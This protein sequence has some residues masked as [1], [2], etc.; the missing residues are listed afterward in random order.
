MQTDTVAVIGLGSI[1]RRHCKNLIDLGYKVIGY[2]IDPAAIAQT[3]NLILTDAPRADFSA[4]HNQIEAIIP[5]HAVIIAN[6]S[7]YHQ[8]TLQNCVDAGK[9]C[10]VEKPLA[11]QIDGIEEILESAHAKGLKVATGFNLRYR[12]VVQK[13]KEILPDLG[14]LFWARFICA[15]YLPDW[16]PTQDY[17]NNYAANPLTGGVIFDVAHEIDLAR[18]FLGN[19]EVITCFAERTG[20]LDML[21]EDKADM[22]IK[23]VNGVTSNIHLDYITRPRQRHFEIAGQHGVLHVNLQTHEMKLTGIE[24]DFITHQTLVPDNPN[25]EYKA[26]LEGFLNAIRSNQDSSPSGFDGLENL[27][28]ILKARQLAGLPGTY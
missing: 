19:G 21:S 9:H 27:K 16:R 18:F 20:L 28:H 24:G 15:S 17:R 8:E 3:E 26:E 22:L 1:G 25:H 13:A 10:F 14:T 12:P 5:S 6:P 4:V 2:D 11:T 7:E 23:H